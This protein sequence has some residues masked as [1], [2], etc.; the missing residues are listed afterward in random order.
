MLGRRLLVLVVAGLAAATV[1]ILHGCGAH[2]GARLDSVQR[3][4]TAPIIDWQRLVT[5]ELMVKVNGRVVYK[6]P[7][8][9]TRNF[10][11]LYSFLAFYTPSTVKFM[12][13]HTAQLGSW[14]RYIYIVHLVLLTTPAPS[15]VF[16][17][18]TYPSADVVAD[19]KANTYYV[20]RDANG[21]I[22]VTLEFL[23]YAT[24]QVEIKSIAFYVCH[25]G[26]AL[27]GS[28]NPSN[29]ILIGW[30]NISLLLN[31]NDTIVVGLTIPTPAPVEDGSLRI[32]F[33][34]IPVVFTGSTSDISCFETTARRAYVVTSSGSTSNSPFAVLVRQFDAE[35]VVVIG[36][37]PSA[38]SVEFVY[39]SRTPTC[40]P[41]WHEYQVYAEIHYTGSFTQ[42]KPYALVVRE[43][44]G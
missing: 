24:Q 12:D 27:S 39:E 4:E 43:Q 18:Y 15:D 30:D 35:K 8:P 16:H 29:E 37:V 3:T 11:A 41:T 25:A 20:G 40:T 28:C 36:F 21:N 7:D 22:Y 26:T 38:T 23:Y 14:W 17:A 5:P 13:A 44:W 6:G 19:L 2:Y 9:P 31:P 10:Y 1:L 42:G 33:H 34:N 32:T